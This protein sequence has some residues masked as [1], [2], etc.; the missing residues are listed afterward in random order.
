MKQKSKSGTTAEVQQEILKSLRSKT[1]SM[2]G[3]TQGTT[4]S[5]STDK[6]SKRSGTDRKEDIALDKREG[7]QSDTGET[8]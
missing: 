8:H 1:G 2:L 3:I 7:S 6:Y 5:S 4:N